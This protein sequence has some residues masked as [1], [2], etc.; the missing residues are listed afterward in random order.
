MVPYPGTEV[1]EMAKTGLDGYKIIS[2]DWNDYNKQIG[3]ALELEGLDRKTLERLQIIAYLKFYLYNFRLISL[4]ILLL[5]YKRA[6]F[7]YLKKIIR[8]K[9]AYFN[10]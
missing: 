7:F 4:I 6:A 10:Q 3:N 9:R 5:S 8:K 2:N 1:Y